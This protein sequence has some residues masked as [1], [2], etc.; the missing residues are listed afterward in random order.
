MGSFRSVYQKEQ[1][2]YSI[3]KRNC[4]DIKST[5][6]CCLFKLFLSLQNLRRVFQQPRYFFLNKISQKILKKIKKK[7]TLKLLKLIFCSPAQNERKGY[8]D[9]FY[10]M[11]VLLKRTLYLFCNK[12]DSSKTT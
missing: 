12:M 6:Y 11:T 8:F 4:K 1:Q 9:R 5:L 10:V 7:E 3:K 2:I